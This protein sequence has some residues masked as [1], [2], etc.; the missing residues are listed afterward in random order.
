M[1]RMLR[2]VLLL[3]IVAVCVPA[4][5]QRF[6][7]ENIGVQEGLPASK[8][9]A[10]QQDSSGLV[11]V[12]T[13]AGLGSYDGNAIVPYGT[14]KGV[15][16]SGART[17][18]LD[19]EQRLWVGHLGGGISLRTNGS[20]RTVEIAGTELTS[21]ITGIAQDASGAIWVTTFGQGAWRIAAVPDAGPVKADAIAGDKGLSEKIAGMVRAHD[22]LLF[23]EDNGVVKRWDEAAGKASM[24]TI[25]GVTDGQR[26]TSLF[27]D[28]DGAIW[29]GTVNNGAYRFMPSS[30]VVTTFDLRNGIPSSIITCIA[31]DALGDVWLGTWDSGI[32]RIDGRGVRRFWANNGTHS[33]SIRCFSMDREGNM[34]IGT[35]D[36]GLDIFKGE[37]FVNFNEQDGLMDERVH[38]VEEDGEGRIWFGTNGGINIF[39]PKGNS[40]SRMRT[41][42]MQEGKLTS[43]QVRAIKRDRN[44]TMWIGTETGGLIEVDP[45]SYRANAHQE[46]SVYIPELKVTAL[47]IG[48]PGEIWIG[49][50]RGLVRVV[51]GSGA[52]PVVY[53]QADG[54][55]GD[56]IASLYRDPHGTLWLGCTLRGIGKVDNGVASTVP[57]DH[58]FTPTCFR[59]D[60]EGRLWVGTEGQGLLVLKD[61][62]V[63]ATFTTKDGLLSNSIRSIA[64]DGEGRIWI[65]TNLGL[66]ERRGEGQ[67]FISYTERAGFTGIEAKA[68]AVCITASGD[69][70][71]GT[72]NGA[73]R[74]VPGAGSDRTPVP[75]VAL[76]DLK[77]N[78]EDRAISQGLDLD[79]TERNLRFT[80]GSVSLTD[81]A[82]VR[83]QY[84]LGGLDPD[85]QPVTDETTANY[86]ALPA[87]S[88]RFKVRAMNRSGIW[89]ASVDYPFTIHPPWWRSWWFFTALAVFAGS[90]IFSYI[91]VRERNLRL[92]NQVLEQRVK[93]RTAEVVKQ[94]EEIAGQKVQ[95]EDLLLNILPKEISDELK[96]KGKATARRH[97][98]VT[99]MFTDMKG[100]TKVAEKMTPEELVSELDECFIHFD[101]IIGRYGIEKI[102]TIGDSYM[103][104]GGVP[105]SDPHHAD[106]AV[107]AALEV[108]E[109]MALWKR[110]REEAGK[111]P[112]MLR[113][114]VHTGPVVAGVVGKR[115]FAYDIWGDTVNTAS[116]MESSGEPGE[117]NISGATYQLIK[118]HFACVHRGQVEAKN[119]G[120]IDMY[121]VTRI[122]P[123][124]SADPNGIRPNARFLKMIGL[125]ADVEQL[126]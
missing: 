16:P 74:V 112:W 78:L 121:F 99:V 38:A 46:L 22:G 34:L 41:L 77:V 125:G 110:E 92:R 25:P 47:E 24:L 64:E 67:G 13:E 124:F 37:R 29:L 5:A 120:R 85:W 76:R 27:E 122:K 108:R 103:C 97:E 1:I 43:N 6:Y 28:R 80:Y 66:N 40:T 63:V 123:E 8:V 81:P 20:F 39:D 17:L 36:N 94:S 84:M 68:N 58:P 111:T 119:K 98:Q 73:T 14:D 93:E 15:A 65:G 7:F 104:A 95:I 91:K 30:G 50:L 118:E 3:L 33:N 96:E 75:L 10:V 62:R 4:K 54:T 53:R 19:P 44:G 12:G 115:K 87:G 57:L 51:P 45:T 106:K 126:A 23:I 107:L 55:P 114:G 90:V 59:M 109:L 71:F 35:N 83:Y 11:W 117:V 102:K 69:L 18:F 100:F 49:T 89:S 31:Q 82:A 2:P 79:H 21:D 88:Y 9:Y 72:A 86:P 116:R 105:T 56:N 113:I 26:V 48:L 60:Q 42:S 70:W 101:E 61:D 52:V 32:A